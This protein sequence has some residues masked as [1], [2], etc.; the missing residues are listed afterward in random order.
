MFIYTH[1]YVKSNIIPSHYPT[2]NSQFKSF[3]YWYI[4]SQKKFTF[5]SAIPVSKINQR[6]M[7]IA[8]SCYLHIYNAYKIIIQL[9]KFHL[10]HHKPSYQTRYSP[11][12]PLTN[13]TR[14]CHEFSSY[15]T[16]KIVTQ[17]QTRKPTNITFPGMVR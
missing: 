16:T 17:Y 2:L 7:P 15:I 12:Y 5:F 13:S 6:I 11:T 9:E 8:K 14:S 3:S 4:F 1:F 10:I